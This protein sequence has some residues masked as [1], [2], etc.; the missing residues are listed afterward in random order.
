MRF[1]DHAFGQI[2]THIFITDPAIARISGLRRVGKIPCFQMHRAFGWQHWHGA[3]VACGKQGC[4]P[5]GGSGFQRGVVINIERAE[6]DSALACSAAG[7]LGQRGDGVGKI[8]PTRNP[9]FIRKPNGKRTNVAVDIGLLGQVEQS[10]NPAHRLCQLAFNPAFSA[11][12]NLA[13]GIAFQSGDGLHGRKCRLKQRAALGQ[14]AQKVIL[15]EDRR[16]TL[17]IGCER[18]CAILCHR[19][20]LCLLSQMRCQMSFCGSQ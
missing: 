4:A 15:P 14:C 11:R 6:N 10:D 1:F 18:E 5:F 8:M 13:Q 20:V 19:Y 16:F 7:F 12:D 2:D 17:P 3:A 9:A